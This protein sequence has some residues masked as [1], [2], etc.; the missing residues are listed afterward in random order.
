MIK[1]KTIVY[2]IVIVVGVQPFKETRLSIACRIINWHDKSV[3]V[4]DIIDTVKQKPAVPS[5]EETRFHP[6]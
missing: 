3:R 5:S 2:V 6:K 4:G 1:Y